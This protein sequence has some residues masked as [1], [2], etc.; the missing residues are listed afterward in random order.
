MVATIRR[1]RPALHALLA[2]TLALGACSLVG[3]VS[4][5]VTAPAATQ[6]QADALA[7]AGRHAE[8]ARAYENLAAAGGAQRDDL[9]L[10]GAE[11]W[12]AAGDTA[13]AKR[14]FASVSP[15]A[16]TRSP[17]PYALVGAE[18]ALA[19]GDAARALRELDAI[20]VPTAANLAQNYWWL[21][22]RGAF[23]LGRPVEGTRALVERERSLADPA[24]VRANREEIYLRVRAAAERGTSLKAPPKTDPVV[25]GWLQL[26]PVAAELAR[27]PMHAAAAL[28]EWKRQFPRHPANDGVLALAQSQLTVATEFPDQIALLL[29]LSGRSEAFGVA[30][31]DG[32]LAAYLEQD[33]AARP[34]LRIYDDAAEPVASAYRRAIEDGAGFVVGPLTKEEVAAVAPLGDGRTPELALNFLGDGLNPGPNFYQFAL[35]PEDEARSVAR[36]L[37]AEGKLK[38]IAIVAGGDWGNRVGS[39]FTQELASLGGEVLETARFEGNR[40]D[41]SDII[42]QALQV[43]SVKGEP[44]THR[45]DASFVFVAGNASAARLILPQL[46]FHYAGDIPVYATSDSYEPDPS[47]NADID[48]LVFPDMPWMVSADPVTARIRD[49]VHAAWPNRTEHRDRLYAFGFDAYRVVPA[50]RAK[51]LTETTDIAGVTGKL[52][53]DAQRRIR[54]ELDWARIKDGVPEVL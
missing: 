40:A 26:G 9:L 5:P 27:D 53:L 2:A 13:A 39:A 35:R 37:A 50:L 14:T 42:R 36:R 24:A 22:G 29:P 38:G 8:A 10:L 25:L 3:P 7:G 21:R 52:H 30:V 46:K 12:A 18:V 6:A 23:L 11:Q 44:G 45:P 19:E 20:P 54:R 43:R 33:P 32:F 48:G 51:T 16:R 28:A 41:F 34:R 49:D 1:P 17:T 31:R 4:Q 47:A 15:A